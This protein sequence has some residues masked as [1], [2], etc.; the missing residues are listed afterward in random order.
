MKR[1]N[2]SIP[3]DVHKALR[4]A[5]AEDETNFADWVRERIGDYLAKRGKVPAPKTKK[6]G[7]GK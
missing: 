2:A 5:L 3:D 1:L 6:R 7:K 4:I